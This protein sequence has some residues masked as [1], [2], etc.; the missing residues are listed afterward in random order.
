MWTPILYSYHTQVSPAFVW[1]KAF[2]YYQFEPWEHVHFSEIWIKSQKSSFCKINSKLSS[3]K[4][5]V[6]S[7]RPNQL[8]GIHGLCL[9][10][11]VVLFHSASRPHAGTSADVSELGAARNQRRHCFPGHRCSAAMAATVTVQTGPDWGPVLP[12]YT[13]LYGVTPFQY[14]GRLSRYRDPHYKDSQAAYLYNENS[15]MERWHLYI[16]MAWVPEAT[17]RSWL[18]SAGISIVEE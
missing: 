14:K 3:V 16:E 4:M 10:L 6:R 5:L 1:I 7:I 9:N 11:Y 12:G 17:W 18:N 2:K 13:V 15:L 8:N